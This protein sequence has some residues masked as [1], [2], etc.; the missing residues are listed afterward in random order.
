M[1]NPDSVR[2]KIIDR[3]M[4]RTEKI[5]GPTAK[6]LMQRYADEPHTLTWF[7][8]VTPTTCKDCGGQLGPIE[9]YP[10]DGGWTVEGL[11][12]K[13]W[14]YRHCDKCGYDWSISRLGVPRDA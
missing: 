11:D 4:K 13:R 10:H 12:G 14:L 8:H 5:L 2:T 1:G 9:H 3:H 7:E 6:E